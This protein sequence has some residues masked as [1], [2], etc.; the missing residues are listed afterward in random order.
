MNIRHFENE[1]D[2]TILER[3]YGYY[4]EGNIL[5]VLCQGKNQYFVQVE[6]S[7]VY[8][9]EITIDESG[10]IERSVCDCPYD[11]GS[12]CK[13]E[14][15]AYYELRDIL[16]DDSDIEV[17]QGPAVTHPK[18]AEVLSA[19][20]KEQLIEDIVEM[21]QQDG[22]LKNSH[23]LK[24]SQGSDAEELDRCKKLIAAIVKKYTGR[25]GF[26]EYRK[27]GS[28]AKEIAEVLEKAWETENVLLTTDIACLVLVEAVEAFQYADD[29]DGDIGWL[30]DEAVDQL[31]EALADNANWEP[32][33]RERLFRKLLQ[34]SE[35]TTFDDWE[36]Y[37][38]ALLGMCAQFAD[39]ETLRN[40]LKANI[41]DLVHAYASQ[42]YQKYTSEALHGIWLGI[43]REYG[44][45]EETEQFI[46]ANL[47]YS[48]FRE[49]LIT[50][51]K[52]END[53]DRVVQ[54]ALEGEELDKGHAGRI[55]KWQEIR[56]AAYR[57]LQLKEEQMRL[58]EQLLLAG[59]FEYYRELQQLAGEERET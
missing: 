48:S 11:L 49:S 20:S 47:H 38:V 59:K 39:V 4:I 52:Q 3:G 17:I 9:V 58:A 21:A 51:Y 6:G 5:E 45:A 26:I 18:L 24:Y 44:S 14:V 27:V 8:E 12:V 23:I 46:V 54:L 29:S 40:A 34:E 53:F 31:H 28:F 41:E 16:D 1:I 22:V 43:L 55:L 56:Y 10:R 19:L 15:A 36:D 25:G 30:A 13:H 37:R 2:R 32:E 33:L 7:E 50:K 57:E 35:R 42:E